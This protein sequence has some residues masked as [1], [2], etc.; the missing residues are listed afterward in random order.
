VFKEKDEAR[1]L[2]MKTQATIQNLYK[3]ILE[4]PL[5]VEETMD[6]QV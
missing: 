3:A 2:V 5:V 1:S 6:E 4:V